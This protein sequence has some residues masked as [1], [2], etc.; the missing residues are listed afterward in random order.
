MHRVTKYDKECQSL[1]YRFDT[2]QIN[3][4]IPSVPI[5]FKSVLRKNLPII[6]ADGAANTLMKMGIILLLNTK[7]SIIAKP[8]TEISSQGLQ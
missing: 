1:L 3:F 5:L 6:T 2:F 7:I 8:T 4:N